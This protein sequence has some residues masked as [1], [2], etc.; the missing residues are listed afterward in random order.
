[1]T[2]IQPMQFLQAA[3]FLG[4]FNLQINVTFALL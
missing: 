4:T 2:L 1:M 3:E